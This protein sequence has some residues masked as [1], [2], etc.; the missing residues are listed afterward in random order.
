MVDV[1][2][3]GFKY[4]GHELF[5]KLLT[6]TVDVTVGTTTEVY[7]LKRASRVAT[8]LEYL[9]HTH[10]TLSAYENCI[11][12]LQFFYVLTLKIECGLQHRTF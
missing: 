8:L 4:L 7:A 3:N 10:L 12:R 1:S 11:A 9:L 2:V 6:L 5:A